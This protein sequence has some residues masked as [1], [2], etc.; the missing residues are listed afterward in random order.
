MENNLSYLL[1]T[2]EFASNV[3]AGNSVLDNYESEILKQQPKWQD[4]LEKQ[5]SFLKFSKAMINPT[6]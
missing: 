1:S 4:Y 5:E 2:I 6:N 3:E